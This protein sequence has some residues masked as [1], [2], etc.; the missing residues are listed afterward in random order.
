MSKI[1][2]LGGFLCAIPI[3]GNILSKVA[4][5]GTDLAR[6]LGK[7]FLDKQIDRFNKDHITG[8]GITPINNEIKDI[9]KV[10]KS[11]ETSEILLKGTA[12]KI[13]SQEGGFLSFLGPLM[14]ADLPLMK[15]VLTH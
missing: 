13:P 8:S 1:V 3:F 4:K 14:A 11:L 5:T 12:T 2:Q 15:N 10:I 7:K 9:K 6:Y